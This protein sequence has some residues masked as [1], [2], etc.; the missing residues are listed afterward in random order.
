MLAD[1]AKE[2]IDNGNMEQL[3]LIF[4]DNLFNNW[5]FKV[6]SS[7]DTYNGNTKIRH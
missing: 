2:F 3:K 7:S 6:L 4:K 1:Q 5:N